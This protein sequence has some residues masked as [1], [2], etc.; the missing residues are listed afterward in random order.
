M[1]ML[2]CWLLRE[3]FKVGCKVVNVIRNLKDVVVLW[4]CYWYLFNEFGCG[5]ICWL[6]FFE[7]VVMG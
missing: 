7:E 3:Y 1:Y 2:Y 6:E 4:Y 5:F